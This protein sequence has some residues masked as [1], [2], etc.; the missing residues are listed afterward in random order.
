MGLLSNAIRRLKLSWIYK[1]IKGRS[2]RGSNGVRERERAAVWSHLGENGG[3]EP[4]DH[5]REKRRYKHPLG[6]NS[7]LSAVVPHLTYGIVAL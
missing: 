2:L 7:Q 3:S 5:W 1:G 4:G 6:P